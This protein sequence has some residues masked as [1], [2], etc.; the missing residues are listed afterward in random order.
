MEIRKFRYEDIESVYK[1][2]EESL[3]EEYTMDLFLHLWQ[4]N[5]DGFLVAEKKGNVVG[6]ITSIKTGSDDFEFY[7]LLLIKNIVARA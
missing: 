4:I 2:A 5:P 7:C 3:K 6:F 1:I